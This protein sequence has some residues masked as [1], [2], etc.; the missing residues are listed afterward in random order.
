MSTAAGAG[1]GGAFSGLPER[2]RPRD[3]EA[4]GTGQMR[5]IETTLLVLVALVLTVATVNDLARQAKVNK[6]LVADLATWRAYTGHDYKNV[7]V[8]QELFGTQSDREVVCGNTKPGQLKGTTQIC[9]VIDGPIA[10]GKRTIQGGWYLP[11]EVED[12]QAL[13]YGCFGQEEVQELCPR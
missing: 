1:D 9:L 4:K 12:E 8:D 5:L 10:G 13:R 11:P 2:I 6:R 3:S 7:T